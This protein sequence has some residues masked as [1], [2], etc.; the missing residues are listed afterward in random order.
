MAKFGLGKGL[1]ALI[2]EH[3]QFFEQSAQEN[4]ESMVRLVSIESLSPNPDQ[5][6]KTFSQASLD[7]LADSIRRHGLLQ[8]LLVHEQETGNY[9]IIAGER[10][11]RA[12][13]LAGLQKVPVIVRA[14]NDSDRH[15]ELSLVENIQRED[16]DPIEEAQAYLK[17]MEISGVTQERIAEMVGKNR[18]TVANAIR[19]LRLPDNIQT[20]IKQGLLSAGHARALLSIEDDTAR[21][22]LFERICRDNLS[23]RQTE[24]EAQKLQGESQTKKP[25]ARKSPP[26][27]DADGAMTLDPILRE[28]KEKLIERF[29]TKVEIQGNLSGGT[30]KIQYFSQEDLQRMYDVLKIE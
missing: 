24:Q 18:V 25:N 12:A 21:Q 20:A 22:I 28:L 7:E 8:P 5:P 16:L 1:G 29:G 17:L 10:R 14:Q 3:Q 15:L 30:I 23:V 13:Q 9:T 6:R 27:P 11:Y 19:L 26:T 2:P 4:S